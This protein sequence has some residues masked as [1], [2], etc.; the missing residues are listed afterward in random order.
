M[1]KF[2]IIIPIYNREDYINLSVKSALSQTYKNIEIIC[3]NDCSTDKSLELLTTLSKNDTRI[4]IVNH[5]KNLGTHMARKSGVQ[6]AT[7]DYILFLDCDDVLDKM[8]CEVLRAEL[9]KQDCDIIDFAHSDNGLIRRP[10]P[11]LNEKKLFEKLVYDGHKTSPNICMKCYKSE[12]VKNAFSKMTDFYSIMAQD[13]IEVI[14]IVWHIKTYRIID[15]VLYYYSRNDFGA[16]YSKK[17]ILQMQKYLLSE[18]NDIEA[19]RLFFADKPEVEKITLAV[20]KKLY[21]DMLEKIKD[22]VKLSDCKK[23]AQLLPLYFSEEAITNASKKI[24]FSSPLT[25]L[26]ILGYR[27]LKNIFYKMPNSVKIFLRKLKHS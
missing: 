21:E 10:A 18:K 3:V 1:I 22:T 13:V 19:L 23:T 25:I 15:E 11:D 2:S 7:G 26:S 4:K 8:A 14:I 24:N 20:E 16:T 27:F 6:N 12:L 9:E 17:N 5:E